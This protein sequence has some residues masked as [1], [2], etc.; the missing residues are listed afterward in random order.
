VLEDYGRAGT[1]LRSI[2][3]EFFHIHSVLK[4]KELGQETSLNWLVLGLHNG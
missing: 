3:K 1:W 4:A 2:W